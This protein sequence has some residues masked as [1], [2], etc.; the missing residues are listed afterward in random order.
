MS[1]NL[2]RGFLEDIIAHPDD[3]TPRLIFADWLEEQGDS[4]RA[5]FIRV[6]VERAR[7]PE[8][9]ARQVRLRLRERELI[10]QHGQ[11]W[12]EELP[13]I[14]GI[15]WEGFRR[16]FMAMA[17]FSSFAVLRE[18]A[19][20]CWTAAPLEAISVRWPRRNE[21]IDT[22]AP[23]AGLREL[24][25]NA[26][27]ARRAVDRLADAP[28][29]STLRVLNV[30]DGNLG[31]EGFRQLVAS[32]YLWNL[33]ALRL[34]SNSIGNGGIS[35]LFDAVALT[36][37]EELD[38]SEEDP[39]RRYGEDPIIEA[40]GLEALAGWSGMTRLRSLTLSGN[41]VGRE[42]LRALLRSPRATGLK[43]LAL[44]DNGLNGSAMQE[45]GAARPELQLDVL[46]IGQNF[47]GDLGAA[48][49]ASAPC[50]RE[51][52]VLELDRCEIELPGARR[53]AKAPFLDSLRRLNVNYDSFG[54]EGLRALLEAKPS[55]LHTLWMIHN[56]L[57]D[58]VISHLADSPVSDTLLEVSLVQNGL[59]DR[60]AEVLAKAKHLQNLLV[61]WLGVNRID[62]SAAVDL[63]DSPLGRRLAVLDMLDE[64]I[65]F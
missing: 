16:G 65:P 1:D 33:T 30:Y 11:K 63:A 10:K 50:L 24:L 14:G 51:L 19:S 36:A 53:L 42:G 44:R 39:Y 27:F 7:L 26:G 64:D 3:D 56:D 4:A 34:P 45:F 2:A 61:L 18:N 49:L 31:V 35:A 47:L 52:K 6:Q 13:N 37:L 21:S 8:W 54:P 28:L 55:C 5:E 12:Q 17:R 41:N 38:L 59:G 43:E 29:L 15:S 40:A 32:P 58:E 60:T 20:T 9:D 25:I 48:E 62:K 46:D 23:I 57:D 22:I